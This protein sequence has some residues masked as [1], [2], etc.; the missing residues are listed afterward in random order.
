MKIKNIILYVFVFII[1]I[2][3]FIIPE[4]LLKSETYDVQ[5]AIYEKEKTPNIES[6][7]YLVNAIQEIGSEKN[8]IK[9]SSEDFIIESNSA[10]EVD[11]DVNL[12][13]KLL[14]LNKFEITKEIIIKDDTKITIG[15]TEK[16]YK[17]KDNEYRVQSVLINIDD[18]SYI[19]EIE[20]QTE[21]IISIV[22]P[23]EDLFIENNETLLKNYIE[24]LE[25]DYI[26]DWKFDKDSLK[27]TK[28]NL[29]VN[30]VQVIEE[31]TINDTILLSIKKL[32]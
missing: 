8:S 10:E 6:N 15:I 31:K 16:T 26:D 28:Y 21:K 30:L 2:A 5:V 4:I 14:E 32:Q 1:I 3:S 22:M 7:N 27:S 13:S 12:Y 19:I 23:K 11:L 18:K 20:E 17:T 25:L 24:Y 29:N 9:I